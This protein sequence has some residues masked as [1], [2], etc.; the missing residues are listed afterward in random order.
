M[1]AHKVTKLMSQMLSNANKGYL[2]PLENANLS[3]RLYG[4]EV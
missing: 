3:I 4:F 2:V 1:L